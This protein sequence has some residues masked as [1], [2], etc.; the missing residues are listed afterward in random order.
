MTNTNKAELLLDC[1]LSVFMVL[2]LFSALVLAETEKKAEASAYHQKLLDIHIASVTTKH[3]VTC[4]DD[5]IAGWCAK[6]NMNK[7]DFEKGVN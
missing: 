3:K 1:F 7:V 4:N 6:Y 5:I 2:V